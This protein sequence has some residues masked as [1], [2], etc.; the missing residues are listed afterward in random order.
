MKY[1][2]M[3]LIRLYQNL[4]I[5]TQAIQS[6]TQERAWPGSFFRD[7]AWSLVEEK[8]LEAQIYKKFI[9]EWQERCDPDSIFFASPVIEIIEIKH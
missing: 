3:G 1:I 5:I 7:H 2:A 9:S 8:R 4:N 6:N